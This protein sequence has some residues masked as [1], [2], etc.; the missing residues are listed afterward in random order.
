VDAA[1]GDE[2]AAVLTLTLRTLG[3]RQQQQLAQLAVFPSSFEDERAAAVL[4]CD[5]SQAYGVLSVLYAHGL[6]QRSSGSGQHSLHAAVRAA[7]LG[8]ADAATVQLSEVGVWCA[9]F[10]APGQHDPRA[11][12]GAADAGTVQLS[13]VGV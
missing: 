12:L 5:E 4:G 7:T 13:E 9:P 11:V 2:T 1:G 8:L 3:S 10:I 6:V